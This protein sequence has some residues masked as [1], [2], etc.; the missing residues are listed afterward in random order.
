VTA[1]HLRPRLAA[2][3]CDLPRRDRELL[4]LIAWAELSYAQAA[5]ALGISVAAVRS[6]LNRIRVRVRKALGGTNPASAD[7]GTD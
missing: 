6:R 7:E 2:V 5:E 1:E 4:L 3:L